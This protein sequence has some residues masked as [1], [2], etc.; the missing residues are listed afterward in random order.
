MTSFVPT[1]GTATFAAAP[2]QGEWVLANAMT[3]LKEAAGLKPHWTQPQARGGVGDAY[4]YARTAG[5]HRELAFEWFHNEEVA[6]YEQMRDE[7]FVR[8]L[9]GAIPMVLAW[10]GSTQQ[11][12]ANVD[13]CIMGSIAPGIEFPREALP[14]YRHELRLIEHPPPLFL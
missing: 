14:H 13:D 1:A 4:R 12:G 3:F 8:S 5:P 11:Q 9:G 10:G 7:V 2:W 6:S